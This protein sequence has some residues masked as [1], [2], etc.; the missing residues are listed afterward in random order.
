MTGAQ[1][2]VIL[3]MLLGIAMIAFN[4]VI[5]VR[6]SAEDD[7]GKAVISMVIM[8]GTFSYLWIQVAIAKRSINAKESS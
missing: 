3:N 5:W 4:G 1:Y 6:A 2:R 8:L 7:S